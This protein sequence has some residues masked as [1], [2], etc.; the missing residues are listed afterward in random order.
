MSEFL[1]APEEERRPKLKE[2]LNRFMAGDSHVHTSES[3]KAGEKQ[4]ALLSFEQVFDYVKKEIVGKGNKMKFVILT[5]H[6]SDAGN[7]S[8][9]DG[10]QL[11]Q[12]QQVVHEF[13]KEQEEKGGEFPQLLCG[14]E[15]DIISAD[16]DLD[17]PD[18][19][20]SKMDL[21]V[22]SKHDLRKV[23]PEQGGNPNAEQLTHIYLKLMD[24]PHVDVIGHPNRYVDYEM[25]KEMDWPAI[26]AKAR[27]T[28]TALEINFKAPMPPALIEAAVKAGVP[29]FI[30]T[31]AH[32]LEEYQRLPDDVKNATEDER[33][34]Y[35][36][37]VKFSFWRRKIY[38]ALKALE[39]AEAD[40][41]QIITSSYERLNNWL[42]KEK[43]ERV[44][45]WQNET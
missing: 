11:L 27:E 20:L 44:M 2:M 29:I 37:G 1:Q 3:V 10:Q 28:R 43:S 15:A 18:E 9:V 22:A 5:E 7:P 35:P 16:G 24:N 41:E 33:L 38:P 8:L 14:V 25:L 36:L 31:D 4:D 40:P 13:M 45:S 34:E 21:V 32:S 19:V 6:P 39:A 42:S 26:F 23:F 30:G 17:V 12:H